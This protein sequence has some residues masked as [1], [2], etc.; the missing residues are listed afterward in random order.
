MNSLARLAAYAGLL[1]CV[2][3]VAA[4]AG[5]A[6]GPL[7]NDDDSAGH[8]SESMAGEHGADE[9]TVGSALSG[10]S[11]ARDGY[12]LTLGNA[13]F[14]VGRKV[15]FGFRIVDTNGHVVRDFDLEGGVRMHLIVVRRDLTG[16]QHL[17][18]KLAADGTLIT[19]LALPTGGVWRAF[20]DFERDGSKTVLAADLF[21]TGDFVPEALP[22]PRARVAVDGY[23]VEL[24]GA[25]RTGLEGEL[26]FHVSRGGQPVEPEPYLGARGHLVALREGD[27][28]YLHVHPLEDAEP[29]EVAFAATFPTVGRYR[30]FLQ[31]DDGGRIRTAAFTLQVRR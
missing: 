12:R 2:A 16:Y 28:G 14:P 19:E 10:L 3:A 9:A 27:L 23:Q 1:G 11:I 30:L 8:A 26:E 6:L 24:T 18:P 22:A 31:F 21:A 13:T 4:G 15:S 7:G 17:H 20:A 5:L 25:P 29:G